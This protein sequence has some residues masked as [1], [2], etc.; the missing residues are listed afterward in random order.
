MKK[1]T[2]GGDFYGGY[3]FLNTKTEKQVSVCH[4]SL[5]GQ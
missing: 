1:A 4:E 3:I 5:S 2:G